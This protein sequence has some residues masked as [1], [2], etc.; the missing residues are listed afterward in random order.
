MEEM[1]KERSRKERIISWVK[2]L[3]VVGFLFFLIKG[4]I[5]IFIFL[6]VKSKL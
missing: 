6:F 5:W 4:L 1:N 2:K 3:G